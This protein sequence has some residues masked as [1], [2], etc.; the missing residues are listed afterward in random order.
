MRK[1]LNEILD[2]AK[3][4][5]REQ[6]PRFLGDLEEIRAIAMARLAAPVTPTPPDELLDVAEAAKR[7]CVKTPWLYQNHFRFD[8]T[9]HIG[10]NKSRL[11]FSA[12][13]IEKYL[14]HD[15]TK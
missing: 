13:G 5:E 10:K 1:E 6:L 2:A 4:L 7:L 3:S 12:K 9:R 11:R 8:F 15:G 14:S